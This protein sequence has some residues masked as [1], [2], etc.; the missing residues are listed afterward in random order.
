[1]KKT[2]NK[3]LIESDIKTIMSYENIKNIYSEFLALTDIGRDTLRRLLNTT[4]KINPR[5]N[6][7]QV[8]F[9]NWLAIQ[10]NR[11]I[12]DYYLD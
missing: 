9:L 4:E 11:V 7:A 12:E 8:R 5:A 6:K 2:I 10:N 3:E 1:M